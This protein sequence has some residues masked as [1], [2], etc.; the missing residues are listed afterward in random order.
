MVLQPI[1]KGVLD[2]LEG[3]ATGSIQITGNFAS[4]VLSGGLQIE[5]GRFK[6]PYINTRYKFSDQIKIRPNS[7]DFGNSV[8]YDEDGNKATISRGLITHNSWKNWN[9][10][11]AG[12][13]N[14]VLV[15]NTT[16]E[17]S[18]AFYGY[19]KASG[20]IMVFGPT[21]LLSIKG[22]LKSEKGSKFAIPIVSTA[23]YSGN[24][25][26]RFINSK[27]PADSLTKKLGPNAPDLSGITMD[28]NLDLTNDLE[29]EIIFDER[30]GEKIKTNG[31][32]RLNFNY[33]SRG[34]IAIYGQYFFDRG[35]Y[36]F[37]LSNAINKKFNIQA[38]SSISWNGSVY[39]GTADIKAEHELYASLN[40]LITQSMLGG[41]DRAAVLS[42]PQYRRKYQTKVFLDLKGQLLTPEIT[43]R[44][45]V[46]DNPQDA[47]LVQAVNNFRSIVASNEA[48][49]NQQVLSLFLFRA[50]SP[51]ENSGVE[52][53]SSLATGTISELLS[54]QFSNWLSSVNNNFEIQL[55]VNGLDANAINNL[56]LR[57]SY[58]LLDGRLKVTRSGGFSNG[59]NTTTSSIAGDWYLE[60]RLT[61]DGKL[62]AKAFARNNQFYT[63]TLSNT[64]TSTGASLFHTASFNSFADLWGGEKR[65]KRKQ[66][67]IQKSIILNPDEVPEVPIDS[68]DKK[69]KPEVPEL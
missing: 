67:E 7:I 5:N 9:I 40:P 46:V 35:T 61:P 53:S 48:I 56:Q 22:D 57:L 20:N 30:A 36:N 32:G 55:D 64:Q 60:Y 51:I 31:N 59:N 54:N 45:D 50:F 47:K 26:I 41:E 16:K 6:L 52:N 15:L 65:R 24:G 25:N 49:L 14:N 33:D 68:P 62:W 21:E 66:L 23:G 39:N 63:T 13:L 34:D 11:I 18:S 37:T 58:A 38:G 43:M 12:R 1:L 42:Q 27:I 4:V 17:E 10:D 3:T 2:D 69:E 19:V 28:F 29:V 8:L 44:V